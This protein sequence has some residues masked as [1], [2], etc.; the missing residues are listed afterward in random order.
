MSHF[1]VGIV[2]SQLFFLLFDQFYQKCYR[3]ILFSDAS[4]VFVSSLTDEEV[5]NKIMSL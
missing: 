2:F 3:G 4:I 5:I 1:S